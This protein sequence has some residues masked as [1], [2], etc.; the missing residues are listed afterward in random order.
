M[1]HISVVKY[2]SDEAGSDIH[3][4]VPEDQPGD[5]PLALAHHQRPF[6]TPLIV[7]AYGGHLDI[8]EYI[9]CKGVDIN[10]RVGP[11][12]WADGTHDSSVDAS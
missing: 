3:G 1:G 2:L 10:T 4:M 12:T 5:A 6:I 8:T 7:A 9:L 11:G